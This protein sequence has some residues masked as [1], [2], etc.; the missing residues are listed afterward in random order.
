MAGAEQQHRRSNMS[1]L[2]WA[3]Y[4][5]EGWLYLLGMAG[6]EARIPYTTGREVSQTLRAAFGPATV[7]TVGPLLTSGLGGRWL[8]LRIP[9]IWIT[10]PKEGIHD[11]IEQHH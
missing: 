8:L 11:S 7:P 1:A 6:F 10:Y 3:K 4:F 2:F 5:S 9:M